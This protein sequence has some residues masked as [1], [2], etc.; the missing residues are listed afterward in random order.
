M[1]LLVTVITCILP[2]S[3]SL[4]TYFW[5]YLIREKYLLDFCVFKKCLFFSPAQLPFKMFS[6]LHVLASYSYAQVVRR[7]AFRAIRS[8]RQFRPT[9]T[10]NPLTWK[11][12]WAPNNARRWQMGFNLAFK[13]LN[14][15]KVAFFNIKCHDPFNSPSQFCQNLTTSV[16]LF[17]D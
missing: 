4:M 3:E 5:W 7:N 6:L 15:I 12:R 17:C 2:H 9:L 14:S 16:V 11:I 8:V 10:L 13:G 1:H